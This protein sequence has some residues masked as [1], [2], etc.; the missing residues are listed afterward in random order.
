MPKKAITHLNAVKENARSRVKSE[1]KLIDST[2]AP[3]PVTV[4]GKDIVV[5][6]RIIPR[7]E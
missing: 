7:S 5:D 3:T 1:T 4:D 2:P 6:D